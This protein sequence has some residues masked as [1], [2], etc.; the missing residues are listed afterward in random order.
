MVVKKIFSQDLQIGTIMNI[1]SYNK[2]LKKDTIC[3]ITIFSNLIQMV[4][5]IQTPM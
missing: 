1:Y 2:Q 3:T 5:V 4:M